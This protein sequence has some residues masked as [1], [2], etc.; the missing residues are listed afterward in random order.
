MKGRETQ[1]G[2]E[3][4]GALVSDL[5]VH[6]QMPMTGGTGPAWGQGSETES[7]LC[8]AEIQFPIICYFS[9]S[10][11]VV[12]K[13]ILLILFLPASWETQIELQVRSLWV[14]FWQGWTFGEWIDKRFLSLCLCPH[15]EI[16]EKGGGDVN[17]FLNFGSLCCVCIF[18][19]KKKRKLMKQ[20]W[21]DWRPS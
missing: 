5:L 6:L 19:G 21:R 15:S 14:Q 16:M 20:S 7:L 4:D 8:M 2:T 12:K 9:R 3:L 17:V 13:I 11:L 18:K 10:E 1:K